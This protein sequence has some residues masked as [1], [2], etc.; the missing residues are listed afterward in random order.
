MGNQQARRPPRP[1]QRQ[2]LDA[3]RTRT[4]RITP[5][6]SPCHHTSHR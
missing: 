3:T 4:L 5:A 2:R 6:C 1:L